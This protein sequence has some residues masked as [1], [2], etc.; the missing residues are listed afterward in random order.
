MLQDDH[1]EGGGAGGDV[2]RAGLDGVRRDHAGSGVA[3][4]RAQGHTGLQVA[5]DVQPLGAGLGQA[6]GGSA[7]G[8]HLGQDVPEF[9][10]IALRG[11]ELLELLHHVG[12]VVPGGRVDGQH[13]GG[14]A[15]AQDLLTGEF[16]VDVAGEGGEV[17][18]PGNVLLPVQDGLVEVG[19]APAERDVIDEELGEFRGGGAGVGVSPGAEGDK[20]G[21]FGVEGHVA[22]HHGADADG[23]EML[24]LDVVAGLHVGAEGGVAVLQAEP[25]G[26]LAVGPETVHE[27]VF[28]LMGALGDGIVVLIDQDGLDAGGS[29]LDAQDGFSGFDGD[30]R[31]HAT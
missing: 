27:L 23:G 20:Q 5:G 19:D 16:P 8:Q 13:A 17:G 26:F 29:E 11:D 14:V 7:G 3:F 12:A 24:D 6:S 10:G 1:G 31:V 4:R 2:A 15:H 21:A 30:P 25:E 18:D 28:P 22:V 9:P